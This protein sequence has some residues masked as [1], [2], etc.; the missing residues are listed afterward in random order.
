MKANEIFSLTEEE[1]KLLQKKCYQYL[2]TWGFLFVILHIFN[3]PF[4]AGL[5]QSILL[6][7]CI[8][9]IGGFYIILISPGYLKLTETKKIR[10]MPKNLLQVFTNLDFVFHFAPFV[11]III[12][13]F[14]LNR[15]YKK[16][17]CIF[18]FV[19][20]FSYLFCFSPYEIYDISPV[21]FIKIISIS[22]TTFLG[23]NYIL[24]KK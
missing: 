13:Y 6:I 2:T 4:F 23:L 22:L 11:A 1:H 19:Y 14:I 15:S 21:D 3:V 18:A 16:D 8:L 10:P 24:C 12:I 5:S 20:V 7:S 9:V 17:G